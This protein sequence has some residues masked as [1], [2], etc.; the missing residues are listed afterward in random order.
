MVR[1]R[2]L[3]FN[4]HWVNGMTDSPLQPGKR[5]LGFRDMLV[6][7][8]I[9]TFA[10]LAGAWGL[11]A[12]L[13]ERRASQS[14]AQAQ[15]RLQR[16]LAGASEG[17]AT[18]LRLLHGIPAA[19]GRAAQLQE[20]LERFPDTTRGPALGQEAR[21]ARWTADSGLN[22][23]DHLLERSSEDIQALSVIWILNPSGDCLAASNYRKPDSFVGTNYRDR[24]YF[25]EAMAG[26]FGQQFAMG[27]RS[28]IPGLF[29]SAPIEKDGRT[30]GVI[31]GKV[32]LPVLDNWISQAD[33]FL[34][35]RYGVVIL[36]RSRNLEFHALPGAGVKGL[37][38]AE[39]QGRYRKTDFATLAITPW[40]DG[41]RPGLVRFNGGGLPTLMAS[42]AVPGNELTVN[43]IEAM[44]GV[45][46]L[47]RDRRWLFALLALLGT[48]V[49]G[50]VA[51]TLTYIRQITAAR[52]ALRAKLTELALAKEAA[53]TANVAKSRFLATMSH[54]IRTPLNGV[55]GMAELL[56]SPQL[57]DVDRL[58]Y[59][60]TILTSG[61]TLLTHINDILDLSKVE[62]GKMELALSA[63]A[64]ALVLEEIAALFSEMATRKSLTLA[65]AWA[66]PDQ[67]YQ[68]DPVRLRQMLSNLAS[69]A[70]KFTDT[71]S[72]R[73]Q[74]AEV[75]RDATSAVLEFSV[76]DTG[77]G[78]TEGERAQLFQPFLQLDS[79]VTRPYAGTGLGLSIVRS[80]ARLMGGEVGVDSLAGSGSRFWF[81]I[82]CGLLAVPAAAAPRVAPGPEAV[83][84]TAQAL[85][86]ILLVED[87]PTNRKVIE[88]L[89]AKRGYQVASVQNGQQALEAITRGDAPDLVLMDCQMPVM[90]GLEATERIR[91]W[92]RDQN[93][94][95]LPIVALTAGAF[96]DDRDHCLAAGMDDFVTKPVDFVG[97]PKVIAK[98][99]QGE[100]PV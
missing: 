19:L 39:R 21:R 32:D 54:E 96:E 62:A 24:A 10:W 2:A 94:T 42:V 95:R 13:T 40:G 86:R 82:R 9:A 77:I 35:D 8:T 15:E 53:E 64:P 22:R 50:G 3:T 80:L 49:I 30:L 5:R 58:D 71:G 83:P 23:V 11:A 99:L 68:G 89:L 46:V 25:Q 59:A 37:S 75:E 73:I 67:G 70:I 51:A 79:S 45:V 38:P 69:N 4:R 88:A 44:P 1:V 6:P 34:T 63:F 27:R 93:R 60:R 74:A 55:L 28:G 100:T 72:I 90:G 48:V 56:L 41:R 87:N 47:D 14:V 43:I 52:L 7:A 16:Q 76:S 81:R 66:G 65:T 57:P 78:I 91:R 31:A 61:N 33:S 29:F 84:S 97:L 85:R 36:A 17:L 26:R 92:E 12:Y 18:N 20:L 98:W